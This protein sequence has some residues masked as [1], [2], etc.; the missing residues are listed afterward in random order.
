MKRFTL[1]QEILLT[2]AAAQA[3]RPFGDSCAACGRELTVGNLI[4]GTC[5]GC[6]RPLVVESGIDRGDDDL[7]F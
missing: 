2:F 6:R 1:L 7:P 5:P 4:K 3:A